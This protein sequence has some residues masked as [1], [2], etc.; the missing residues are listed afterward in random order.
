MNA[1]EPGWELFEIDDWEDNESNDVMDVDT[2]SIFGEHW[3]VSVKLTKE[4][5][6]ILMKFM[7]VYE[8]KPNW[9]L[10]L[11]NKSSQ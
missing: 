1:Y 8:A 10:T 7:L 11:G 5:I 3:A 9:I 2:S 6:L 4:V